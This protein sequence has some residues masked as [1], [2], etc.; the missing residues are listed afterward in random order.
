MREARFHRRNGL[1][2][3]DGRIEGV[4]VKSFACLVVLTVFCLS[5]FP[6]EKPGPPFGDYPA[7]NL[8]K[9]RPA[10]VDFKSHPQARMYRTQLRDQTKRGANFAGHF[11]LVTWGCG[12][13]C[14]SFAIVDCE[15]GRVYF[16]KDLPYVTAAPAEDGPQLHFKV[17]S[18]LFVVRGALVE[19]GR[20]GDHHFVWDGKQ[21]TLVRSLFEPKTQ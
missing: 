17:N 9:G 6:A 8:F 13:S 11:R 3:R 12:T 10:K 21:L 7:T 5:A 1:D 19:D 14:Q 2:G 4:G 18:R 16:K 15:T 20:F